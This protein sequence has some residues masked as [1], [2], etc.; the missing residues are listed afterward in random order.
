MRILVLVCTAGALALHAQT[1]VEA[2]VAAGA[3]ATGAASMK[4]VGKGIAGAFSGLNKAV[5]GAAKSSSSGV[6]FST[7]SGSAS[8]PGRIAPA[9]PKKTY[10]DIK[11]AETGLAYDDLLKRFGPPALELEGTDGGKTLTYSGKEGSTRI[12]VKDGKIATIT[13]VK[14]QSAVFTL[15][16][17]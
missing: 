5:D 16:G 4:D 7:S 12:E 8:A 2:G 11:K 6:T 15:P 9:D 1:A 10:E 13:A 3:S 17:K 14:P